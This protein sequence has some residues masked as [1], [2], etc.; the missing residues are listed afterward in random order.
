MRLSRI[1]LVIVPLLLVLI[2]PSYALAAPS[3]IVS[4]VTNSSSNSILVKFR[5]GVT[6]LEISQ[7][8]SQYGGQVRATIPR[9]GVQV[10]TVP[11][12]Q[13]VAKAR[14]YSANPKVQFAE[15]DYLAKADGSPD[16]PSFGSQWG[17]IKIDAPQ[18]WDI[19]TGSSNITIAVLDTGVDLDHPDLA[20]KIT[21]SKNF[22]SSNTAD[23]IYGHGT[24]VAGIAAAAT[25]NEVGVAGLGYNST[26]MNVKVLGDDGYGSYSWIAQGIIWAA[27]N[28]A[29]VINMSLGGSSG[30][31]TLESAVNYAW[32]K[33]ALVVAAAGNNGSSTPL[34][35]A[36]YANSIA[37]AATDSSDNL[38]SW[39]NHG[40]WVDV[41]AP[42]SSIYSTL[43]NG[44]YGYKSGTSMA[45]PYAAGLA[46]LI[47]TVVTDNNGN[48]YLN[49]EVRTQIQA[50]CDDIGVSGIG[51]GRIN[52]YKAV[53]NET[54]PSPAPTP[55][56]GTISGIVQDA[57][58]GLPIADATV[59]DGTRSAVTDATG[60]YNI[61]NVPQGSYTVAATARGYVKDSKVVSV[62][63]DNI[64]EVD[65][66]LSKLTPPELQNMWIDNITFNTNGNSL[67][68]GAKVTSNS[69]AVTGA[70]LQI[71]VANDAGQTWTLT[72]TSDS[73]G[74]AI[75]S[76][77][78]A[79]AGNY[80]ATANSLSVDG[81]LWDRSQGV[82]TAT[83][84]LGER[85]TNNGK[86][87]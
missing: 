32:S 87:R 72:G 30:S 36:Y 78:K 76:L 81:Y 42:G 51:S 15:P 52:A 27:D 19:T 21:V 31:S 75:F 50:T 5:P 44:A 34:Y 58:N 46:A 77:T 38:T 37:V 73:T 40:D 66:A 61:G 10:V 25:N 79:P 68:L 55:T 82:L 39:S 48:G 43:I 4:N 6:T 22:T 13:V 71:I 85:S 8:H 17:L 70:S 23:D 12:D 33:G 41:A 49:D 67:K 2:F 83:Y 1:L 63:A 28:G 16:D 53:S 57:S 74:T 60:K 56:T 7:I 62:E 80:T 26:V 47:F 29:K 59:S 35:P 84:N 45:T 9:I 20:G 86:K 14:A 65:Y 11:K 24:H 18:A 3:D 54:T 69:G 64:V